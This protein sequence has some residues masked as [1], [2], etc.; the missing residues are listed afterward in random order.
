MSILMIV[1]LLHE[2]EVSVVQLKCSSQGNLGNAPCWYVV[3]ALLYASTYSKYI[4]CT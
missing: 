4:D 2:Q 3:F 1:C